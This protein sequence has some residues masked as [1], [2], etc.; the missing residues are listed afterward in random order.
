[1]FGYVKPLQGELKVKEYEFYKAAYCGL[2]RA[3][4]KKSRILPFTLSYDFVF[5]AILRMAVAGEKPEVRKIRCIA[6]PFRKNKPALALTPALERT[7]SAAAL[8]VYYNLKDDV[9]DKK[10]IRKLGAAALLPLT[11][12]VRK[13]NVGDGLLDSVIADALALISRDE[14]AEAS[15][16]YACA[17]TFG[18]L[19]GTVFADGTEGETKRS[20]FQIGRRVGRWIY[21]LDAADDAE[22]DAKKKNYNPFVLGGDYLRS[23]F[24]EN[25]E[26]ALNCELAAAAEEL[27]KLNVADPGLRN[28]LQNILYL[29]MPA[30]ADRVLH[31]K[32]C[33]DCKK[34]GDA[35]TEQ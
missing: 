9:A 24:A 5:L 3:L 22:K 33:D 29:G 14:K 11:G 12:R 20:L 32:A 31:R 28:I 35:S 16:P 23:D 19:L 25:M 6:H 15:S 2:C 4:K 26:I 13:K 1:M 7:A 21:L 17:E 34:G 27:E 18:I 10:G 30:V 8:L